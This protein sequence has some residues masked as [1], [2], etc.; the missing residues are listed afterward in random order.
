MYAIGI[1]SGTQGTKA[2]VVDFRTGRVTGSGRAPHAMVRG[3]EAGASEQDPRTWVRAME[4]ALAA[5]AEDPALLGAGPPPIIRAAGLGAGD[6][7]F[8]SVEVRSRRGAG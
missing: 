8:G 7:S 3:L 6:L 2:V 5:A 1:D 4:K